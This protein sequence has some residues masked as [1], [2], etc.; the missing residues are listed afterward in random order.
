[1]VN[2]VSNNVHEVYDTLGIDAAAHVLFHEIR[3]CFEVGGARTDDRLI[4]LLVQVITQWGDIMALTRHGINR[5][6]ESHQSA[7]AKISFEE[8][9]DMIHDACTTGQRDP[10]LGPSEVVMFGKRLRAGTGLAEMISTAETDDS[11]EV[12]VSNVPTCST[13]IISADSQHKNKHHQPLPQQHV[14]AQQLTTDLD[15]MRQCKSIS[16]ARPPSPARDVW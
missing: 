12:V 5:L 2:V 14:F 11:D 3:T 13:V 1:M 16:I 8:V 15:V 6:H 9:L 10:L 7:V 4:S